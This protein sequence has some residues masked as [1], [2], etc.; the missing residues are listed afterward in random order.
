LTALVFLQTTNQNVN[1]GTAFI[2]MFELPAAEFPD[3]EDTGPLGIGRQRDRQH[4]S[5]NS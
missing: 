2:K 3:G 5:E 4:I 1:D